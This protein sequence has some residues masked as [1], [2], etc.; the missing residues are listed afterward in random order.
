MS[1]GWTVV[2]SNWLSSGVA[3]AAVCAVAALGCKR[4]PGPS[5]EKAAHASAA[6][7]FDEQSKQ[8][9]K[10]AP[11][12]VPELT[13]DALES[14]LRQACKHAAAEG[15]RLLI[16]FSAPWCGDCRRLA[17]MKQQAPLAK[18]LSE[19]AHFEVNIGDFDQH[20]VLLQHFRVK[21]IARWQLV[22]STHCDAPA[23]EWPKVTARTLEPASGKKR[24]E[25]EELAG[26][27]MQRR[28]ASS[29]G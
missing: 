7:S 28:S 6:V 1:V 23:T 19:I 21:S 12:K 3:L 14:G 11:Y 9:A 5:N 22:E 25:V 27:L 20:E 2:G 16:E 15:T 8:Q 24:V 26:W 13:S 4:G 18:A 17:K 29:G 10:L